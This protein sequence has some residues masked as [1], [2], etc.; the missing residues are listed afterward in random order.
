MCLLIYLF[1][2]R[3]FGNGRKLDTDNSLLFL[4]VDVAQKC[5]ICYVGVCLKIE[6]MGYAT[7]LLLFGGRLIAV[8]PTR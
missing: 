3:V 5:G 2:C 1:T 6:G 8:L 4:I 7:Y